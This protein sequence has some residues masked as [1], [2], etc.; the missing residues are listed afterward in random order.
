MFFL[1]P[2]GEHVVEVCT[3]VSCCLVGATDVVAA[4]EQELG[5][6]LGRDLARRRR[7]AAL[8]RVP[9]RL[10]LGPGRLGRPPLS[11]A[12]HRRRCA[13]RSSPTSGPAREA[14]D[15]GSHLRRPAPRRRSCST[16][17]AS[18]RDIADY[19]AAGGYKTA[20]AAGRAAVRRVRAGAEGLRPARSWRRRLPDR[21]EGV[22]HRQ[23]HALPRRQRRRVRARH[24]QGPRADAAQPA[25]PDR[26]L[27]HALQRHRLARRLH[28]HPR[29]VR[30]RG[31]GAGRGRRAG[32][33]ARLSRHR[34]ARRAR[35]G[36]HLRAPRRGRLH[37]RRGDGAAVGAQRR[38]RPADREAAVPGRVRCLE[39]PDAAQQRRDRD[40]GAVHLR[41]GC[42]ALRGD[43][44]R[45]DHGHAGDVAVGPRAA[46]RQLRVAGQ[47]HVPRP[48]R[49]LRR[50]RR[51]AA[52]R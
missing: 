48:D 26:G 20:L 27:H 8:G 11:R 49:R 2:V 33:R 23:G 18:A 47:R 17:R 30:D 24:L 4:F 10:R 19:E 9:G 36:R 37:L 22:V 45:A 32:V 16:S 38:P 1:E 21:H 6:R 35:R 12:L 31:R 50:R 25:R 7:D 3:N 28:L 44:H 42:R 51:R 14:T 43:A 46:P 34:S 13:A 29:R 5:C 40:D 52:A 39:E 15:A 41:D